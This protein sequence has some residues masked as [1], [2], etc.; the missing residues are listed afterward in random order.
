MSDIERYK[1]RL[2]RERQARLEAERLLEEKS[3]ML[4]E[5]N[6]ALK[7]TLDDLE[8]RVADRTMEL[9]RF[10]YIVDQSPATIIIT[11]LDGVVEYVNTAF[12]ERTGYRRGQVVGQ[13]SRLFRARNTTPDTYRELWTTVS[14]GQT[15]RGEFLT[16]TVS[17]DQFWESAVISPIRT[18]DG[19]I[20]NYVAIK[21]DITERKAFE[22]DLRL[23]K[24]EA[25][26]AA[27]A[28]A[29]FLATMSHEIR[30]PMNG[31]LSMANL[32]SQSVLPD[33]E[34]SLVSVIQQSAT[35]LLTIIDDILDF[36][37]IEAGRLSIETIEMS[38]S[39]TVESVGDL[40]CLRAEEK[41]LEF[42]IDLG[43][44]I[45]D[46]VH[47]DPTRIR[48]I[49]YNLTSNAIKFTDTGSVKIAVCDA[50][51]S[52][53]PPPD[54]DAAASPPPRLLRFSVADTGIGLTPDQA[55]RLF[56][57]FLQGDG[58]TAR[59]YGGTG[60]GLSIC[61][62]LCDLMHGH[63][64]VDSE[65]ERGSTFW[66][67]IPLHMVPPPVPPTPEID[68]SDIAVVAIGHA[69]STMKTLSAYLRPG[70]V[71]DFRCFTTAGEAL[72][73]V[74]SSPSETIKADVF[75][76][77]ADAVDA[78][79]ERMKQF[80]VE[81]GHSPAF[82]LT[83]SRAFISSL[84]EASRLG[85]LSVLS[86]PIRRCRLW[87]VI[88]AAMNRGE[89]EP[90]ARLTADRR[91][92]YCPP[93][94][95][96]A[97]AAGAT[98]LVAEDNR[99][100]QIVMQR[101]LERVGFAHDMA[102]NGRDALRLYD[103]GPDRYG[104]LLTDFHMPDVDGFALTRQVRA[105]EG[106]QGRARLPIV[107]VTADAFV[108][109]EERC[110][111]AD[112]DGYISKPIDLDTLARTLERW[113]PQGLGLRRT[114]ELNGD[115]TATAGA[116]ASAD[117]L[118]PE[119]FSPTRLTEACGSFNDAACRVLRSFLAR[120][121]DLLTDLEAAAPADRLDDIAAMAHSIK[122]SA[123]NIGAERLGQVAADLQT[124]AEQADR[125]MVE[126]LVEGLIISTDEL[127]AA[128]APLLA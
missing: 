33:D 98:V 85:F 126:I 45:P 89:W 19:T 24:E 65:P 77:S 17:G 48:Q 42:V 60:L 20:V 100:N 88:A 75:L 101:L 73:T 96:D 69:P 47:G 4:Y 92:S 50:T 118:D 81:M 97:H 52:P 9:A 59:K 108:G 35:A 78:D 13:H 8:R 23:A 58:S 54:G 113:V 32:L 51:G 74:W 56:R 94:I 1:K 34:T 119:V 111:L 110:L 38:L 53:Q 21:E 102:E 46:R 76:I 83:S 64:A 43:T 10:S 109:M 72:E 41:G 27:K 125:D 107:A 18:S 49:L 44:A 86:Y 11:D 128:V 84:R 95:D 127:K 114:A 115:M 112:M 5:A 61:K 7:H 105:R 123:R 66:F 79:L 30:T 103:A 28:K 68:I 93:S 91:P 63:I 120:T 40:L 55:S 70:I 80:L 22:R 82:I 37:K 122:G 90:R 2:N 39:E 3:R 6:E 15:W 99:T 67:D 117:R 62:A 121:D 31:V 16:E 29:V 87:H 14:S 106:V 26:Q 36:S 104:V 124:A 57:P 71:K 25:E 12:C 116:P